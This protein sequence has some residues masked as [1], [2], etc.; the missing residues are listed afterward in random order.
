MPYD[1]AGGW[2]EFDNYFIENGKIVNW[3]Y[4]RPGQGGRTPETAIPAPRALRPP[5]YPED[6]ADPERG[7]EIYRGITPEMFRAGGDDWLDKIM[8]PVVGAMEGVGGA[9][10]DVGQQII[11]TLGEDAVVEKLVVAAGMYIMGTSAFSVAGAGAGAGAGGASLY[12]SGAGAGGWW[13]DPSVLSGAEEAVIAAGGTAEQAAQI[14]PEVVKSIATVGPATAV[15]GATSG[16]GAAGSTSSW[17][18]LAKDALLV[19]GV[20][21]GVG[22]ATGGLSPTT[23]NATTVPK[24]T[25]EQQTEELYLQM[26]KDMQAGTGIYAKSDLDKLLAQYGEAAVKDAIA[27]IPAEKAYREKSLELLTKT[28]EFQTTQLQKLSDMQQLGEITG[29]LTQEEKDMF[30]TMADQAKQ[31]IADTVN[32]EQT[33]VMEEAI[34]SLVDRGVLQGGV[35][36]E[37]LSR[38]GKRATE[39][40]VQ[41]ASD[42]ETTKLSNMLATVEANKNRAIQWANVGLN[43]QQIISGIAASGLAS[44]SQPL[45]TAAGIGQ[46]ASALKEATSKDVLGGY[47]SWLGQQTA[48]NQSAATNALQ[49]AIANS[50]NQA[51]LRSAGLGALG[52]MAGIFTLSSIL[53]R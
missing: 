47:S 36:V 41:G 7:G 32:R 19:T 38:I 25:V 18:S 23:I 42:V 31:K 30:Q 50:Q 39:L 16:T 53:K 37:V 24:G 17:V 35:G 45:A 1:A 40:I 27:A 8:S 21:A 48:A 29:D 4:F 12:D 6:D 33:D 34:A 49:A 44:A 43:Q 22:A 13:T 5:K 10:V 11:G 14:V 52:N 20:V 15:A 3:P 51:A 28:L 2:Y 26:L 46:Y 9:V